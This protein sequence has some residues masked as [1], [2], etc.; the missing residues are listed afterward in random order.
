MNKEKKYKALRKLTWSLLRSLKLAPYVQLALE[1]TLVDDGWFNSYYKK[2]SV[3]KENNP[4]PWNT[5]PFIKFIEP[6]LKDHFNIFEYG[7]GN[8]TI[9]YSKRVKSITAV[10]ND[11]DWYEK[12]KMRLPENAQVIYKELKYGGEY[13][14]EI[15]NHKEQFDI[16]IIDGRDRE[17]SIKNSI[18]KLKK[19][20][21]IIFDNSE[22]DQYRAAVKNLVDNKFKQIAFWGMSPVTAHYTRQVFFIKMIIAWRFETNV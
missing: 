14:M 6:R 19:E 5:Y 13:S 8:S 20:G 1:S 3:D 21:I 18:I 7:C 22:R 11:K 4:I 12:I 10:E 9:W 2:E 17:N 16:I 15:V